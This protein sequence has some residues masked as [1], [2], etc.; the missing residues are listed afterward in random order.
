MSLLKEI[1]LQTIAEN[2]YADN[3]HINYSVNHDAFVNNNKIHVPQAGAKPTITVNPTS[4]PLTATQRTDSDLYYTCDNYI[5]E[6]TFITDAEGFQISYDNRMSVMGNVVKSLNTTIGSRTFYKWANGSTVYATTGSSSG[7]AL[8]SGA[9][10]GR[11]SICL[12]DVMKIANAFDKAYV[13]KEGRYLYLPTDMYYQLIV[14][15][16]ILP[17]Y[18]LGQAVIPSG[19]LPPIAGFTV[20]QR[21][22]VLICDGTSGAVR[23]YGATSS[24]SDQ[25]AGFAWQKDFV[26]KGLGSI[27]NFVNAG[28]GNG[29]ALYQGVV[30]SG[31]TFFGASQMRTDH[32]GTA[33]I[34]QATA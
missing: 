3:A 14:D 17:A 34:R 27:T 32:V 6:P 18:A 20:V 19:M 30:I 12:A 25:L 23:T 11:L 4:F 31:S 8:A 24:T 2:L 5:I 16:N 10:G 22:D 9:T 13:P 15:S 28:S 1:W 33:V 26:G 21:P 7:T 29:D